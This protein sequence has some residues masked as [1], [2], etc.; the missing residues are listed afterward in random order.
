MVAGVHELHSL[1][2]PRPP[3]LVSRVGENEEKVAGR[4]VLALVPAPLLERVEQLFGAGQDRRCINGQKFLAHLL[5][6]SHIEEIPLAPGEPP[7]QVAV[8]SIKSI[9][10]LCTSPSFSWPWCYDTTSKYFL[11]LQAAGL[12]FRGKQPRGMGACYYFPLTSTPCLPVCTEQVQQLMT[13]RKKVGRS[14]ALQRVPQQIAD[15]HQQGNLQG[16]R[17]RSSTSHPLSMAHL[18]LAPPLEPQWQERHTQE[19]DESL[20]TPDGGEQPERE[21]AVTHV[22]ERL[23]A[24]LH[25]YG[26]RITPVVKASMQTLL[27]EEL[28][29]S[30]SACSAHPRVSDQGQHVTSPSKTQMSMLNDVL[31]KER[32]TIQRNGR[33]FGRTSTVGETERRPFI[34]A[35]AS[36]ETGQPGEDRSTIEENARPLR[37]S[38]ALA[39]TGRP[40]EQTSTFVG[41]SRPLA[42]EKVDHLGAQK[43]THTHAHAH[44]RAEFTHLTYSLSPKREKENNE[45]EVKAYH[46]SQQVDQLLMVDLND[47]EVSGRPYV[48]SSEEPADD[49]QLSLVPEVVSLVE[50][51]DDDVS[52]VPLS[53]R[54]QVLQMRAYFETAP[55]EMLHALAQDLSLRFSQGNENAGAYLKRLREH[56][57]WLHLAAVD[58]LVRTWLPDPGRR[59]ARLGGGWVMS[60]YRAYV[61]GQEEPSAEFVAWA[62]WVM[63]GGF[64]YNHLEWVL[65]AISLRGTVSQDGGARPFPQDVV[66]D[67]SALRDFWVE[68]GAQGVERRGYLFVHRDG[69]LL[70][71][72]AYESHRQVGLNHFLATPYDPSDS[73]V[74][75]EIQS[76]LT[77]GASQRLPAEEEQALLTNLPRPLVQWVSALEKRI[78]TDQYSI[79]VRLAPRIRRRV[80]EIREMASPERVWHLGNRDHILLWLAWYEHSACVVSEEQENEEV[81]V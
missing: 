26:I 41:D 12:L 1:N 56:P 31:V 28:T 23:V 50:S 57:E 10:V 40:V 4:N 25:T 11:L 69:E 64:S 30:A 59:P 67:S 5:Q 24:L 9:R 32:A 13:R 38:S 27:M 17:E 58:A 70:T 22:I 15:L 47:E 65:E 80:I 72:Q 2:A 42:G 77:W 6:V 51:G 61:E 39:E 73:E 74:M 45:N 81:Y 60:R 21:G 3:S 34:E 55:R 7:R 36:T 48:L 52:D 46:P 63:E 53:L 35:S 8:L 44:A 62:R 66:V 29:S 79:D 43:Q 68:G 76:Y 18:N 16:R 20:I 37:E 33:S 78:D 75:Y 19:V 49:R 54:D 71:P 14:R